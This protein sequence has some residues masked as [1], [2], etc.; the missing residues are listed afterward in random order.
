MPSLDGGE[1][2]PLQGGQSADTASISQHDAMTN[3]DMDIDME[4]LEHSKTCAGGCCDHSGGCRCVG[5]FCQVRNDI[6]INANRTTYSGEGGSAAAGAYGELTSDANNNDGVAALGARLASLNTDALGSLPMDIT[7]LRIRRDSLIGPPSLVSLRERDGHQSSEEH[8]RVKLQRFGLDID[9][10]NA[11][12]F[13]NPGDFFN[14]PQS[15]CDLMFDFESNELSRFN[16]Q[17]LPPD[18]LDS[19]ARN[20]SRNASI[21]IGGAGHQFD[22]TSFAN[23]SQYS[24]DMSLCFYPLVVVPECRHAAGCA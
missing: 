14:S 11:S 8:M 16:S 5:C 24:L 13:D 21:A 7:S 12:D 19:N 18:V 20:S 17:D 1:D 4:Q 22:T 9:V 15:N 3:S 10:D 6:Q 23:R 2:W